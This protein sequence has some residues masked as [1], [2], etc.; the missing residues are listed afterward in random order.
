MRTSALRLVLLIGTATW[1]APCQSQGYQVQPMLATL[2]PAGSKA[3]L[4]MLIKNTGAVPITLE[5]FPFRATVDEAGTPTRLDE[6]K[7]LLV[8]P[9][10]TAI[11]PGKEQTVQVRYV[12]DAS[13]TQARMYGVRVSQ[14]PVDFKA[15]T[16]GAASAS[17]DIK[18]SF[19]FLSH[20][21]VSP[22]AA[23]AVLSVEDAGRD[24]Q[25]NLLVRAVNSGDGIAV[26]NTAHLQLVDASG[27]HVVVASDQMS[28]GSFSAFMPKQ[29]RR[30]SVAS[31][32]LAGLS[33]PIKS[34]IEIR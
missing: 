2:E 34:T 13:F 31:K 23:K 11:P 19:N 5:M 9:I 16:V 10:Q 15:G 3:R 32:A 18:V 21:I 24:A 26:L 14:L 29:T 27:K 22:S 17:T 1:F 12:G 8:Y 6:E 4:T 33:G 7:D 30:V 20:I 28:A 25:G